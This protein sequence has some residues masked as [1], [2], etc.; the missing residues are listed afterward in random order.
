MYKLS[1]EALQ[2]L[3]RAQTYGLFTEGSEAVITLLLDQEIV[4]EVNSQHSC[5]FDINDLQLKRGILG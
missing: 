1:E 2:R 5:C 3:T 4:T